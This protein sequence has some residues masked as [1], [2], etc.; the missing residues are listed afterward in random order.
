M[1]EDEFTPKYPE[2]FEEIDYNE[3]PFL[4]KEQRRSRGL[5]TRISQEKLMLLPEKLRRYWY[6]LDLDYLDLEPPKF[7]DK[8]PISRMTEMP[9]DLFQMMRDNNKR[10][11]LKAI[12]LG[13]LNEKSESIKEFSE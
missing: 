7:P 10:I 6:R 1:Y 3:T 5:N 4:T 13:E 2:E 11:K 12:A 8:D 9:P